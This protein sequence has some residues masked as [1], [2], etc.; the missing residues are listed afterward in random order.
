[1]SP[2]LVFK[3]LE[4]LLSASVSSSGS[5]NTDIRAM[6]GSRPEPSFLAQNCAEAAGQKDFTK[7]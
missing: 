7:R 3:D 2:G 6:I 4:R 5:D 1:M